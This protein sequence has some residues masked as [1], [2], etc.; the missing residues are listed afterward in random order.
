MDEHRSRQR[1]RR[2]MPVQLQHSEGRV[3][4]VLEA[5]EQILRSIAVR[6][7][8]S[9]ILNEICTSLDRQIGG[10]VSLIS[11]PEDDVA[12]TADTARNAALFGL[13]IFFSA[14]IYGDRGEELGS[15]EMYCCIARDPSIHELQWIERAVC[16]AAIALECSHKASQRAKDR[17]SQTGSVRRNVLGWPVSTN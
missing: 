1:E 5:E 11:L 8:V 7:P 13:H 15:L 6:A 16:L 14:G 2:W 12:S 9:Q 4:Y 17:M 10:M 3:Q